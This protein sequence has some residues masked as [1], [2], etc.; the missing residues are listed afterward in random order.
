MPVELV[1]A[2]G[3]AV[4]M[5]NPMEAEKFLSDFRLGVLESLRPM[6]T[7]SEE[8][9]FYYWLKLK[10]IMRIR[11]FDANLGEAA[12]KNIYSSI[13]NGGRLEAI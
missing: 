13:M 11:R 7:F 3:M 9:I 2:A 10:L 4:E 8:Y 12:Y 1:R 5:E 6:D